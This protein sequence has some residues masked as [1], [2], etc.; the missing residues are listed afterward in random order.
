MTTVRHDIW[1]ERPASTDPL[2]DYIGL[3]LVAHPGGS[4]ARRSRGQLIALD[5]EALTASIRRYDTGAITEFRLPDTIFRYTTVIESPYT[6]LAVGQRRLFE[7]YWDANGHP[8]T[9]PETLVG[10]VEKVADGGA[11]LWVNDPRMGGNGWWAYLKNEDAAKHAV[12]PV[13]LKPETKS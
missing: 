8:I 10:S 3:H 11:T 9:E 6:D 1:I 4:L 2:L 7:W 5:P 13:D 12:R